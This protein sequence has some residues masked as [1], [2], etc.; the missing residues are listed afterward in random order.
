MSLLYCY[1]WTVWDDTYLFQS[2]IRQ[3][4]KSKKKKKKMELKRT[5]YISQYYGSL[6]VSLGF[7]LVSEGFC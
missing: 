4:L 6:S 7:T 5:F 3:Y 2:G 1:T